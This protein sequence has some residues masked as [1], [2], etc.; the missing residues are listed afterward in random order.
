MREMAAYMV[1]NSELGILWNIITKVK[2]G[3]RNK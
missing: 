3:K 2:T 1:L